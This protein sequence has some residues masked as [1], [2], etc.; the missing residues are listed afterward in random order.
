MGL[1]KQMLKNPERIKAWKYDNTKPL[2][3]QPWNRYKHSTQIS[4][5]N[6]FSWF[7]SITKFAYILYF[8]ALKTVCFNNSNFYTS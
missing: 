8:S 1:E 2:R 5:F 7:Y 4:N 3:N 6:A